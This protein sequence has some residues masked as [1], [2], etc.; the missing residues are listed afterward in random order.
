MEDPPDRGRRRLL[1][2]AAAGASV[3][4][5]G[6][7]AWRVLEGDPP[8]STTTQAE[9]EAGP[10]PRLA[11]TASTLPPLPLPERPPDDPHA[12][13][14]VVVLGTLAIPRIAINAELQEGI[15][16]T[17]INRGPGHWPGTAQPGQLG[18]LVVAGHRTLFSHPFRQL[19]RLQPGDPVVFTTPA[20]AFT[21]QVR[22]IVIVDGQAVDIAAQAWAHTATLFACHP[23]GSAAQ[24][25]VAKLRLLGPDGRPVDPD[26]ALPPLEAGTQP[27]DHTLLM[28]GPDPL[29]QTGG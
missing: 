19:D 20:G 21:Y 13:T 23:P 28:R 9:N 24:R 1:G 5:V 8:S 16:L 26:S 29:S 10:G 7:V 3:A 17:A 11:V 4:V 2:L 18:N 14:P 6:G 27:G 12:P 15:T 22:G 25:I